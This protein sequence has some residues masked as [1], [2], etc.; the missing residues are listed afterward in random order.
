MLLL[1]IALLAILE[2]IDTILPTPVPAS[3][4]ISITAVSLV[5]NV[6]TPVLHVQAQALTANLVLCFL[7]EPFRPTTLVLAIPGTTM[8]AVRLPVYLV[9]INV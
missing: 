6:R 5:L 1:S 8:M 4:N 9:L 2:S 7:S 3:L